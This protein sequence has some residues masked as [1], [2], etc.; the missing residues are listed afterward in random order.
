MKVLV[1]CSGGLDSTTCLALAVEKYG[2]DEVLALSV[3]YGQKHT[4]EVAAAR[5]VADWYGVELIELDLAA[6]FAGA[7]CSLL[8]GSEEAI[9][10]ESYAEQLAQTN[11]KPVSTYVPF[12]N[13]LFLSSAASVALSH[14]CEVVYYGAHS[15]D[16]AGNA[17][18][19]CSSAFNQAMNT[20][21]YLGSGEQLR[22]EA[23]FVKKTK[24]DVVAEGLRLKAPYHLTWSCYEG[25]E[26]PCGVCGT[27]RDRA[28]AFAANGVS[29][30][31]IS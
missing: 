12:R 8:Q 23:P 20:A 1:L 25:G 13:G 21:I 26:M 3:S 9:P 4:K 7:H 6:I 30:P 5:Q 18:P 19:D 14:D 22:I 2:A 11:G 29:D 16:A 15:D 27:C 17:Y 10:Q 24:A 31:A 28:A